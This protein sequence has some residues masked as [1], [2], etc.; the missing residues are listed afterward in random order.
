MPLPIIVG[1]DPGTTTALAVLD[2]GGRLLL[3]KSRK[4]MTKADVYMH[5]GALGKPVIV[6]G[7]RNPPPS[8]VEKLA[9]V[10]SARLVI[11]EENLSKR[12][13]HSL[14]RDVLESGAKKPNQ[15]E[16]D[17]LASALFACNKIRPTMTRVDQRLRNLG[18]SGDED[19]ENYVK[20]RVILHRDHVKRAVEGFH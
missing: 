10:F 8:A 9:S 4:N 12:D 2:T 20:A 18:R 6:A 15:H 5:V 7:D 16:R 11:P 14:A 1:M 3:L 17:A 13:K 19:L